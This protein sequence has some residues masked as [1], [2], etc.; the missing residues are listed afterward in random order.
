LILNQQND[1]A[2][3]VLTLFKSVKF[4]GKSGLIIKMNIK[5]LL[6]IA[7]FN[8]N[9]NFK[10]IEELLESAQTQFQKLKVFHGVATSALAKAHFLYH[11]ATDFIGDSRT[12]EQVLKDSLK[13]C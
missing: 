2:I 10:Q 7:F 8:T 12:E 1:Q 3:R 9:Q 11:R 5:K 6:A 13:S 4:E